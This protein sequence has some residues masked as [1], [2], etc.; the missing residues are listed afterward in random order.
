MM[1]TRL[2]RLSVAAALMAPL[3]MMGVSAAPASAAEGTVCSGN[4]GSIKLSP[5]LEEA[6][7]VQTISIKGKLSGCTG[8]TVTGGSYVAQLKTTNPV[9]C[10]A[11]SSPG[12]AAT[13]SIVIKWSPKGQGNSQGTLTMPLTT[14]G[15]NMGGKLENGLLAGL[16]IYAP[17]SQA[18]S[19][20]CGGTVGGG[21]K[22]KKAKKV[23]GGTLTGSS[24]FRVTGPPTA[25][26]A[27]PAGGGKY[28][29]NAVVTTE[30]SCVENVFGPG[31]ESCTDSNGATGGSGAL[32]TAVLGEHTYSVL[33]TSI[34]GQTDRATI[35]YEVEA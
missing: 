5:G 27:S 16:H 25:T 2:T 15:V 7:H 12:E 8:G 26:I 22:P 24:S 4:S 32:E 18:Y 35:S 11:L 1:R 17:V 33:A 10:S 21:K 19:G 31:L 3:A 29:Q 23:K 14:N 9:S 20:Q 6:A 13:G 30:F 28:V 34:D